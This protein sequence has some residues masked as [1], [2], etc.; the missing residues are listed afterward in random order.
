MIPVPK[1]Y[2]KRV[3]LASRLVLTGSM[4]LR[5]ADLSLGFPVR[6]RDAVRRRNLKLLTRQTGELSAIIYGLLKRRKS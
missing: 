6:E 2:R 4:M 3:D 1:T 5:Q